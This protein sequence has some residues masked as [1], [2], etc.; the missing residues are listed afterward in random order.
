MGDFGRIL[1]EWESIRNGADRPDSNASRL[2]GS[3]DGGREG[4]DSWFEEHIDRYPII[5]K[6]VE[7]DAPPVRRRERPENLPV[8]DSIDLHGYTVSE[9]IAATESFLASCL[10]RGLRK[11]V[12]I[13]GKGRDGEGALK[14]EIR[15][16][17]EHHAST[18]ALGYARGPEGGRGALW[19]VLR[20]R[21]QQGRVKTIAPDR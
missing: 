4:D 7:I 18:G 16:Y 17:L 3:P 2:P 20:Y 10:A 19:V 1:E 5:D 21:D 6:D 11:I 8:D 15:T 12:V 13:H 9:A 14:R